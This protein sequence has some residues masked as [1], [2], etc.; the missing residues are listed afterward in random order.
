MPIHRELLKLHPQILICPEGT[1]FSTSDAPVNVMVPTGPKTALFGAG[2]GLE[3]VEVFF[4]FAPRHGLYLS[5]TP[6]RGTFETNG[7]AAFEFNRRCVHM[8]ERFV[9]SPYQ[10]MRIERYMKEFA[11]TYG[12]TRIDPTGMAEKADELVKK[13][14]QEG[15]A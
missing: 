2:F 13:G 12:K 10:S 8:A 7:H 15:S 14:K 9:I 5:R 3:K 6:E 4:P 11:D 1:F